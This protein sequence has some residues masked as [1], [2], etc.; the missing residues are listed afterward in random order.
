M[1]E[2]RVIRLTDKLARIAESWSPRI[3]ET[4]DDYDIK[5]VRLDGDFLWHSHAD[6]DELFLVVSGSFR[7]DFRDRQETVAA[8]E[9]IVVPRGM[10]HKPCAEQPCEVL[11]FE[12]RGLVNTG[13][14]APSARTRQAERI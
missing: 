8:G 7:M 2:A 5:L 1:A 10:E 11:L 6:A 3:V 4:L 12:R 9:L 13:D 14:A